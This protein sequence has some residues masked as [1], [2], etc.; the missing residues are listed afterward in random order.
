MRKLTTEEFI[1][2]AKQIHGNKY[3]YSKVDYVN[4]KTKICI[5]CPEHGEFWQVPNYHLTGNGCPKCALEKSIKRC[6][7]GRYNTEIFINKAKEIFG[8]TYDY[9]KVKYIDS[10]TKVLIKC[11][12]CNHEFYQTPASH[13]YG[14]GCAN[15]ANTRLSNDEFIKRAK[16]VHKNSNYDYSKVN[17]IN[18]KTKVTIICPKHGEFQQTPNNHLKGSG[19]PYCNKSKGE[20]FLRDYFIDNKINYI[21][22]YKINI[23]KSINSSGVAYIDFYIPKYNLFIEYNGMQHYKPMHF[24]GGQLKFEIQQKR[25]EFVRNYCKLNNIKL[26]EVPYNLSNDKIVLLLKDQFLI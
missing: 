21:E 23:D 9:S 1:E 13:L 6:K 18:N 7:E 14:Y 12:K 8:N 19:C 4:I 10:K 20:I 16:L 5:I 11:N 3:N 24:S 17:Y 26:L 22:Q 2:K 25:D 15:C